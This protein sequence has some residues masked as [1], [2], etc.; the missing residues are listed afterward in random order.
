MTCRIRVLPTQTNELTN[1]LD[2]YLGFPRKSGHEE[3]TESCK[4]VS[5]E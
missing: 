1:A 4:L 2:G 3:K 5:E